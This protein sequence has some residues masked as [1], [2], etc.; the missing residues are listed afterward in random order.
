MLSL[1]LALVVVVVAVGSA[2]LFATPAPSP[3]TTD[4]G[5]PSAVPRIIIDSDLSLWWDD[6]T[7]I[8]MANILEQRGAV[9]ILGIMSDIR[10]PVAVGAIDAIDTFYGH[11]RIPLGAVAQ[12][13]TDTAPH[14]YSNVLVDKLPHSVR[15]SRDAPV[16]VD[17]YRNLLVD[18]PNHSV[19]IVSIGAYTKLAGLLG[20]TS[21]HGSSLD[22]RALVQAKV[23]RLVIED[24]LFPNGAPAVTNQ[25]LDLAAASDVVTN[26][27]TP[28][29]WV[30]GFVGIQTKVGGGLCSSVKANNPMRIAYQWEFGCGPP[31]DG[32]WDGPTL[33]YAVQGKKGL[34]SELGQGGA[35]Y[36]N[37][38]GGLSWRTN[39]S[40][41]HDVYVHVVDQKALNRQINELLG[42]K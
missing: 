38:Q 23:K 39:P 13:G 7:A 20:S 12:S 3:T 31:G 6:A 10:N 25:K 41:P 27:P 24:G 4:V 34:F 5:T 16:A 9:R 37:S 8:G 33:L 18:Q 36:I 42:A 1:L 21:G 19:T 29:A 14:G 30:D 26:W 22:G 17:L 32:D 40:R 35:A 15:S 2:V 11:P 28:M